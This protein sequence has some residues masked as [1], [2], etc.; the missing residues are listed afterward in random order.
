[1]PSA[2]SRRSPAPVCGSPA[3]TAMRAGVGR[4]I[5]T[6][7]RAII[8]AFRGRG[9]GA[10]CFQMPVEHD[11]SATRPG[12]S[13][14]P[15]S[16]GSGTLD[17]ETRACVRP[18]RAKTRSKAASDAGQLAEDLALAL[19]FFPGRNGFHGI[20]KIGVIVE[21]SPAPVG[22]S[23]KPKIRPSAYGQPSEGER[24]D[25]EMRRC[26][27]RTIGRVAGYL[28]GT[29]APRPIRYSRP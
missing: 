8:P 4:P 28:A 1:M 17:R 10:G 12:P 14:S 16:A 21:R 9:R 20:L 3:P 24:R 11:G 13:P 19:L 26:K 22:T 23:A 25:G 2:C 5:L 27:R 29:C 6:Q 7:A 18:R 15:H